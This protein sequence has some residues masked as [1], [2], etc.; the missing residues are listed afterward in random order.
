MTKSTV[1]K[2]K[3]LGLMARDPLAFDMFQAGTIE[4][5][6]DSL[7]DKTMA[8]F[9]G[10]TREQVEKL[11]NEVHADAIFINSRYQVNMRDVPD[12]TMPPGW[13]ALVHLSIKR[14]DKAR[15]GPEKYRDFMAIKDRLVGPENEAVEMYPARG[16]EYDTANE[17]HLYVMKDSTRRWPFGFDFGGRVASVQADVGGARQHPFDEPHHV[18]KGRT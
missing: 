17:Y 13:P 15:I 16:R 8:E 18:Y 7:I 5:I 9:P 2:K 3:R 11:L 12:E 1:S 10:A 4:P 14:R 6:S